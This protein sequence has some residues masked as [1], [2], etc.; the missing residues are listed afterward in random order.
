MPSSMMKRITNRHSKMNLLVNGNRRRHK[1]NYP[2]AAPNDAGAVLIEVLKLRNYMKKRGS[3]F[4]I[5]DVPI[6]LGVYFHN[7]DVLLQPNHE[8]V[9]KP[10]ILSRQS[11]RI[12]L[13]AESGEP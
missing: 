2:S 11:F 6:H 8:N 4:K 5:V 7:P 13:A 1:I 3:C 12:K 10:C 9:Q